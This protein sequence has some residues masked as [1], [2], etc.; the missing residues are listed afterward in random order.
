MWQQGLFI[1]YP[2][3]VWTI[4]S[5]M[6]RQKLLMREKKTPKLCFTPNHVSD[7]TKVEHVWHDY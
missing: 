2:L 6:S 3:K 1:I 7:E 4:W 5:A